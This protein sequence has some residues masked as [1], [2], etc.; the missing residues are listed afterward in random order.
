[1]SHLTIIC[2]VNGFGLVKK[3]IV[4]YPTKMAV[5]IICNFYFRILDILFWKTTQ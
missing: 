2:I 1:M 5:F 4:V 3:V